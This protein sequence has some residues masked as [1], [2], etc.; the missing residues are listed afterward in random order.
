MTNGTE[1]TTMFGNTKTDAINA[2]QRGVPSLL[3]ATNRHKQ[4]VIDHRYGEH[5]PEWG[6]PSA[7]CPICQ[8]ENRNAS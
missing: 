2:Y 4:Q 1:R 3:P 5:E 6:T 8:M 7:G